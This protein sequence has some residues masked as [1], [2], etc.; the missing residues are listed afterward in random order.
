ML[1]LRGVWVMVVGVPTGQGKTC[2][3]ARAREQSTSRPQSR[4]GSLV[5]PAMPQVCPPHF[6]FSIIGRL[7]KRL[8]FCKKVCKKIM[9]K[10]VAKG[11]YCN[12]LKKHR[13]G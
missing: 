10:R 7:A 12:L 4:A 13:V 1:A 11:L 3:P 6:V 2:L 9:Q 5:L 8:N